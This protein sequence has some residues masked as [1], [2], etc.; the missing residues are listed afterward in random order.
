MLLSLLAALP[1]YRVCRLYECSHP[2]ATL[3]LA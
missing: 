1:I 2:N 3:A